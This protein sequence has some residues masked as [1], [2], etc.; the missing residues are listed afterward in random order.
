MI[1]FKRPSAFYALDPKGPAAKL[2]YLPGGFPTQI[3]AA[4]AG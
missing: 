4:P 3:K 2:R 1:A